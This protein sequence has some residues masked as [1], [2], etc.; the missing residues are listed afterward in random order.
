[1]TQPDIPPIPADIFQ[2]AMEEFKKSTASQL[3]VDLYNPEGHT[4]SLCP[5][6]AYT[7][8]SFAPAHLSG[9]RC[10]HCARDEMLGTLKHVAKAL[11]DMPRGC[12]DLLDKS[13]DELRP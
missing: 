11:R 9:F 6:P 5:H 12:V 7:A 2:K 13:S 8:W 10:V 4:C 1:M 3:R